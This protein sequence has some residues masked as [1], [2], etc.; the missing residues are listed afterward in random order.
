M[1]APNHT[2]LR[3]IQT[4]K[5]RSD[6]DRVVVVVTGLPHHYTVGIMIK[7][8]HFFYGY[9]KQYL[10]WMAIFVLCDAKVSRVHQGRSIGT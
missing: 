7:L 6:A 2:Y 5:S 4:F 10:V 8:R 9:Q 1:S 3:F